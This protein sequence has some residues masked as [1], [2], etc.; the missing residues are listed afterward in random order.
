MISFDEWN[1]WYQSRLAGCIPEDWTSAPRI[2]EDAYTVADAVVV[3]SLLISLLRHND[4]V[5]AACQAQLVNAIAPIRAE[6]TGPAWRQSTFHPFALTS[7][8]A[9]GDVLQVSMRAP[10]YG[11]ARYGEVSTLDAVATHDGERGEVT[12]FVVNRDL[13]ETAALSVGLR[14]FGTRL[15]VLEAWTLSD[16]DAFAVNTQAEPHRV[17]PHAAASAV[18]TDGALRVDLPPVSWTAVRLGPATT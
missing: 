11:T 14:P 8:L 17:G 4:R 18:V 3:G 15:R 12:V 1:V 7:R 2:S 5:G 9:R 10:T 6:P 13:A 16:D